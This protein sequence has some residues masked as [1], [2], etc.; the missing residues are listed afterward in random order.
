MKMRCW[1]ATSVTAMTI[2]SVAGCADGAAKPH[3][4]YRVDMSQ[5]SLVAPVPSL[6]LRGNVSSASRASFF[7]DIDMINPRVGYVVGYLNNQFRIWK[8]RDG[9]GNWKVEVIPGVPTYNSNSGFPPPSMSFVSPSTGWIAWIVNVHNHNRL[10]VCRTAD[11]GRI[12]TQHSQ[13]VLPAANYVQ[14]ICFWSAQDG[15]IRAFSGGASN[16]GDMSVFHTIDGGQSWKLVSS[17]TGYILN[18]QATP[19]ALPEYDVPMPMVFTSPRD[20][21]AAV[22]NVQRSEATLYRTTTA[23]TAWYP[24][25]LPVPRS[26]RRSYA[27]EGYQP[28]FAGNAGTVIFQYMSR[29]SEIVSY[30]TNNSGRTWL[31]RRPISLG[32]HYQTALPCFVSPQVGWVAGGSGP[33]LRTEDGGRTWSRMHVSGELSD[34]LHH[35]YTIQNFDMVSAMVGWMMVENE[36]GMAGEVTTRILK[37]SNGGRTW[38]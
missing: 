34:L 23:G 4:D 35:G 25:H 12:W 13:V 31:A 24:V 33:M 9:G 22:G 19:H 10:M 21:W 14:Q 20:G 26:L 3:F 6:S 15:W 18:K 17:A 16:Q 36:N 2:L 30:Y 32:N 5:P 29:H 37:S 7:T 8:T 28:V 38:A 27:T 1:L 11:G